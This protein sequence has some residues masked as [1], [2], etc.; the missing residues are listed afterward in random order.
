MDITFDSQLMQNQKHADIL[1]P[2]LAFQ[3]LQTTD[4]Y[5]L[6]FSIGTDQVFYL[7]QELLGTNT[8]WS[9]IDL[10]SGLSSQLGGA[11]VVAKSFCVSQNIVTGNIDLAL[12]VTANGGDNLFIAQ[13]IANTDGAW[14]NGVTWTS[15]PYDGAPSMPTL[16]ITDLYLLQ[17]PAS[18][19]AA[20]AEYFVVD[21]G[22]QPA[23]PLDLID[24]FYVTPG[25]TPA[26]NQIAM[27]D[28]SAGSISSSLG[29]RTGDLV[30]GMYTFGTI[31]G[32]AQ[33]L[34]AP[35]F[36]PFHKSSPPTPSPLTLPPGATAIAPAMSMAGTTNLFVAAGGT[37]YLFTP[38][39]QGSGA[40]ALS[41]VT[42]PLFAG[43]T[44]LAAAS[45]ATNTA[46]WGVNGAQQL[47]YTECAAGSEATGPWSTPL[48]LLTGVENIASFL[49]VTSTSVIFAHTSAPSSGDSLVQLVQDPVTSDWQLRNILLPGTDVNDLVTYDSF[50]TQI[51]VTDS[52][53]VGQQVTVNVSSTSPVS[54]YMN[55]TYYMLDADT[56]VSVS[57]DVS[58]A[59]TVI[60]ETG[61]LSAVCLSVALTDGSGVVASINPM[62]RA[63]ATLAKIQSGPDLSAVQIT[64]SDGTTQPLLPSSVTPD[65]ACS[66]ASSIAKFVKVSNTLP[67]NGSPVSASASTSAA[68]RP[69][70]RWG[71]CFG[72][73]WEYHEEPG[74]S[75]PPA[76]GSVASRSKALIALEEGSAI[77][78]A[79]GDLFRWLESAFESV[80]EFWVTEA[81]NV[82]HFLVTIGGEVYDAV[83]DCLAAVGH[84]V[85][86]LFDKLEV[87]FDDVVKWLGFVF[88]WSDILRTHQVMKNL[89]TQY[90]ANVVSGIGDLAS[91]VQAVL[92]D[93]EAHIDDWAGLPDPG[94]SIGSYQSSASAAQGPPSPQSSWALY[95]AKSNLPSATTSYIDLPDTLETILDD[96]YDAVKDEIQILV[97]AVQEIKSQIIDQYQSLTATQVMKKLAAILADTVISSIENVITKALEILQAVAQGILGVL[98]AP[99]SIPVLSPIYQAIA[100]A[101][102]SALDLACLVVAIPTTIL[103]KVAMNAAPFPDD[104]TTTALIQAPDWTTLQSLVA[105]S[106]GAR[107]GATLAAS[108]ATPDLM[109]T[110]LQV[111]N[112]VAMI[113]GVFV[114]A[115]A[116]LKWP[117][118]QLP[119][120]VIP[121]SLRVCA[122]AA[123]LPY[124]APNIVGAFNNPGEWYVAMNDAMTLLG[125]AKTCADNSPLCIVSKWSDEISP[126]VECCINAVWLAPAMGSLAAANPPQAS[127]YTG[128]VANLLFDYG[129]ILAP[130]TSA[131]LVGEE[132]AAY[133]FAASMLLTVACGVMCGGTAIALGSESS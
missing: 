118:Q 87:A 42:S 115:F 19:D 64:N 106:T 20:A 32:E 15:V 92:T 52:Y 79:F 76:P 74:G 24:R 13:G 45:T 57:T 60:Q 122:V 25:Q 125:L 82:Y 109:A 61:S 31:T 102:L 84:A 111:A 101:P 17:V 36:N 78:V 119:V 11:T 127:D 59:L 23:T 50:T 104:A 95:H 68:L 108:D 55:D 56:T 116:A 66:A 2:D 99:I 63:F 21:A 126:I 133:G 110:L 6:F 34:F 62:S 51:Q 29:Q 130:A 80:E 22:R 129:G 75:G 70:K 86:F 90:A 7:T 73:V 132:V 72:D 10:S 27:Q 97:N 49:N 54:V 48:P 100:G 8:G 81:C 69:T 3:V 67:G 96:L 91:T 35:L 5:T 85:K 1:S 12:V 94:S 16:T 77:A 107:T 39:N 44:A 14:V 65:Q 18:G 38:D 117:L 103:Y 47:F 89:F 46:V 30:A 112:G 53:G 43:A 26:W 40:N 41:I 71:I 93:F 105:G 33:L 124:I 113:G 128:Y 120:P 121:V 9:K 98:E 37:L 88:N 28:I 4:G 123:Y 58:G 114:A 83:L 131:K